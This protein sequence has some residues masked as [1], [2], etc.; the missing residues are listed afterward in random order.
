MIEFFCTQCG[1]RLNA[2]DYFVGRQMRCFGCGKLMTVPPLGPIGR[3]TPPPLPAFLPRNPLPRERKAPRTLPVL[4]PRPVCKTGIV[5]ALVLFLCGLLGVIVNVARHEAFAPPYASAT[6]SARPYGPAIPAIPYFPARPHAVMEEP[7]IDSYSMTISGTGPGLPMRIKLYLPSG[8]LPRHALPCVLIAPAGTR[9]V[10]GMRLSSDDTPE[11]LPYVRAGFCV[12]AYELSGDVRGSRDGQVKFR[13]LR[14]PIRRF[15]A[16]DG[17][18]RNAAWAIDYV[19]AR[20]PEV[21]PNQLYAAGHSSAATMALNLAASDP[22]IRG[23]VAYAPACDVVSYWGQDLETL[24]RMV[25]GTRQLAER[26]SP[27]R[28][29]QA[30]H[31]PVFLFHADDDDTVSTQSVQEFADA[32]RDEE[33]SIQFLRVRTGG[34][35][36][37]MLDQ[38][39]P[40]AI[41][42]LRWNV[43]HTTSES[44]SQHPQH[45]SPLLPEPTEPVRPYVN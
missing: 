1:K 28:H 9:L 29:V 45:R 12:L 17:G 33:K 30:F 44:P 22:R 3:S 39:I 42:W 10:H 38:G 35:Y 13:E 23:V 19:L 32:L 20:V 5:L 40:A 36:Q 8:T 37:S 18:L 16:A 6:R 31:C 15:M 26:A 11:H 34:H 25:P 41:S 4:T 43:A 21:D 7:G 27:I 2:E 24:D 14:E